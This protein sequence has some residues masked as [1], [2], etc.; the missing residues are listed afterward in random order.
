MW[1]SRFRLG[2]TGVAL[3]A[4]VAS[5]CDDNFGLPPSVP[6]TVD[7]TTLYALT[8]TPIATP[9]A[10]DLVFG[11]A[12]RTDLGQAFDF[13]FDILA[14]GEARLYPAGALR[15]SPEAGILIVTRPFAEVR[16]APLDDAY[17]QD[18]SVV[19]RTETVFVARSRAASEGCA[20]LGALPRYGKFRVLAIDLDRR[21]IA[22]EHLVNHN[23][24]Y[25]G[26]EPGLPNN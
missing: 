13:A 6:N 3:V 21:T 18:S 23:C 17:V 16:S 10:Y 12:A 26:L 1:F 11:R 24:G 5:A 22:F 2:R 7:T 14:N 25:R 4:I 19:V 9:S 15:L 8:G 20:F